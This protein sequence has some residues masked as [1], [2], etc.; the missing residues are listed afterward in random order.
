MKI[1]AALMTKIDNATKALDESSTTNPT[2]W[3]AV[4][5]PTLGMQNAF[6]LGY[7]R[8]NLVSANSIVGVNIGLQVRDEANGISAYDYSLS[9]DSSPATDFVCDTSSAE[10]Y[11]YPCYMSLF[12]QVPNFERSIITTV[13]AM[14]W[15]ASLSSH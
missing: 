15:T 13:K 6:E 11:K 10:T 7:T 8:M 12:I 9:L 3:V 5:D 2:L 14:T 1:I 4:Y